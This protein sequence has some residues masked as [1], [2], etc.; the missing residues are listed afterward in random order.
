MEA[1]RTAAP[2]PK[3]LKR[4]RGRAGARS[5][6]GGR[7]SAQGAGRSRTALL[8]LAPTA[9]SWGS[10]LWTSRLWTCA[11]S[12]AIGCSLWKLLPLGARPA[13]RAAAAACGASRVGAD[14]W[15]RAFFFFLSLPFPFALSSQCWGYRFLP[16]YSA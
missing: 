13:G 9:Q 7:A 12:A 3:H 6:A 2:H 16:S 15:V 11:A 10:G 5:S 4:G 8:T 14:R 1:A